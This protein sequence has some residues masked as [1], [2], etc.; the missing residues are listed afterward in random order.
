M[1]MA[2]HIH[3]PD[4][5][6]EWLSLAGKWLELIPRNASGEDSFETMLREKGTGQKRSDIPH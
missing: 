2:D 5:K 6:S 4:L 1:Q 3:H